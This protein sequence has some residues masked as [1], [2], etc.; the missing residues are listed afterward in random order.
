MYREKFHD[1]RNA[2]AFEKQ[3]KGWSRKKKEALFNNDW[4]EIKKLA[5]SKGSA[6]SSFDKLRMTADAQDLNENIGYT[7][8]RSKLFVRAVSPC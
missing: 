8:L 2:I 1:I 6:S 7:L 4:E 5:K 3:V